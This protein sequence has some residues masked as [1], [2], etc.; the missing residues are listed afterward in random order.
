MIPKVGRNEPCPC[1]SGK[2]Y[3][4]C[5]Y[6]QSNTSPNTFPIQVQRALAK[7]IQ[8][9]KQQ[10]LGRPMISTVA[11]GDRLVAVGSGVY[12][13]P[14]GKTFHDFLIAY[15]PTVF[16]V[17]WVRVEFKK[18]QNERHPIIQ[19]HQLTQ[20]YIKQHTDPSKPISSAPMTGAMSSLLNLSYNLYLLQ[21]NVSIQ[22]RLVD[23]LK[24]TNDFRGAQFETYVA[25]EFIKAAFSLEFEN[26]S[27]SNTTHCEFT[28]TSKQTGKKYSVEAKARLP[29]KESVGIS[30]QLYKAL[31]KKANHA[32]IVFIDHNTLNFE[33]NIPAIT[34]EIKQ[35]E[36]DLEIDGVPAPSCYLFITNHPF[37]YDL[38]G[39]CENRSGFARGFKILDFNFDFN[40]SNIRDILKAREKHAD[41]VNLIKSMIDHVEI[42]V[43]F[44]GE[45]PEFAFAGGNAP[46]RLIIGKKYI[47]PNSLGQSV[48]GELMDAC[49]LENE[50]N[51]YGAYKLA[52]GQQII[53]VNPMTDNELAA[54]RRQPD[55]FFGVPRDISRTIKNPLDHFD[56][57]YGTYKNSTREKLLEFLKDH[58]NF[59]N[60]KDLSQPELA[61]SYCEAL[62]YASYH[63]NGIAKMS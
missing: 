31:R 48:E 7:K 10:G 32:R 14:K 21:H 25:A 59:N 2:K 8:L 60:L 34:Q 45:Q 58:P 53:C 44:D 54:F 37:E 41:V 26:E 49:V 38:E 29:N 22:K 35:K 11:N 9:Q 51:I 47:V 12:S 50:K 17:E 6:L 5:H 56:F 36:L 40:F 28:A 13:L 61:I 4:N 43:T 16:G 15:I 19:W 55:T 62:V 3:K 63:P 1:G 27:D 30:N 46:P 52:D 23:R 42:P 57:L 39:I 18:L 24:N 20:E 33:E